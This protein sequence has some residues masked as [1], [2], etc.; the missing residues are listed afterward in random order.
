MNT[1]PSTQP[2]AQLSTKRQ[3]WM[4]IRPYNVIAAINRMAAAT[5]SLRTAT[6]TSGADYNGHRVT[7]DFNTCRQCWIAEYFWAERI[8]LGRGNDFEAVLG[9][10]LREYNRGALGAEVWV[11]VYTDEE[12]AICEKAGLSIRSDETMAAHRATWY[13]DLHGEVNQA[14]RYEQ[15]LGVPATGFLANS[16]SL[17]EY[18]A[19]VEEF[20]AERRK[21]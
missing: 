20:L 3:Y 2:S 12:A 8:V 5:G 13:T 10:A 18:Q 16:K 17:V 7:V 9:S 21:R 1:T 14:M 11:N 6:L 4:P 19:K 15:Q